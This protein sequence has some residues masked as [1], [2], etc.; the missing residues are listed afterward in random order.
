MAEELRQEL[1]TGTTLDGDLGDD[2]DAEFRND[3]SV[4]MSIR[5]IDYEHDYSTAATDE[6]ASVEISKAPS[7][8]GNQPNSPFFRYGQKLGIQSS[9]T[10][11]AGDDGSVNANGGKRWGRGQVILEPN[12]SLFVNTLKE[13][14]GNLDYRYEIEYE[15]MNS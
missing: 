14:G 13:S 12:E 5:G 15:F 6:R 9:T 11:A 1:L 3:S 8:R 10:G 7:F 4:D 2:A